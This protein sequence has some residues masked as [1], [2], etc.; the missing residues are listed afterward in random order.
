MP[1]V[2][3][4]HSA[5][6]N[7]HERLRSGIGPTAADDVDHEDEDQCARDRLGHGVDEEQERVCPVGLHDPAE[8]DGRLELRHVGRPRQRHRAARR[9]RARHD[10]HLERGAWC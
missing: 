10:G 7:D 5:R 2:T 8:A 9:Q 1:T 3:N 4:D 6:T